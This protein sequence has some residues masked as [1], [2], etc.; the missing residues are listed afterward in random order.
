MREWRCVLY[1]ERTVPIPA[2]V[3]R[4]KL[5]DGRALQRYLDKD[6][7]DMVAQWESQPRQAAYPTEMALLALAYAEL[8]NEKATV[9]I[10]RLRSFNE[11]RR[12]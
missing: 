9:L 12:S 5:H 11:V 3:S 7:P 6:Y 4:I 8:G 1:R 2:R 10:D